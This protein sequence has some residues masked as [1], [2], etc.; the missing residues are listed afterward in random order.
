MFFDTRL[1]VLFCYE[2]RLACSGSTRFERG[3]AEKVVFGTWFVALLILPG[4]FMGRDD[5]I[6]NGRA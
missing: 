5:R 4:K 1:C 3:Q 2:I 6:L